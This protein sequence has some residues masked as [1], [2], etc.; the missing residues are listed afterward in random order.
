MAGVGVAEE[1]DFATYGYCYRNDAMPDPVMLDLRLTFWRY[2]RSKF[3]FL[4]SGGLLTNE[5]LVG[6]LPPGV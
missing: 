4:C 1:N 5:I 3:D 2:V 6:I